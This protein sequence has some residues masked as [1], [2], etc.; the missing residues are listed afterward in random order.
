MLSPI[1]YFV[2]ESPRGFASPRV[3]ANNNNNTDDGAGS[4]DDNDDLSDNSGVDENDRFDAVDVEEISNAARVN[5][6]KKSVSFEAVVQELNQRQFQER[7]EEA[8]NLQVWKQKTLNGMAV[9][10]CF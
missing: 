2:R 9:F 6:M 10:F 8:N 3:D 1:R 7:V 4:D 5:A